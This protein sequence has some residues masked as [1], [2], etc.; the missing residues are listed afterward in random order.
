MAEFET[1]VFLQNHSPEEVHALMKRILPDDLDMSP[2]GHAYN[3]TMPTALVIAEVCEFVLPE[4]IKLIFPE[5]SY[6]EFVDAH[7]K[8]RGMTRRAASAASGKLTITGD[9]KTVIPA[10]S[11]FSTAAVNGEASVDYKTL[12]AVTIPDSGSVSVDVECATAGKIGNTN[13]NTIVLV[14]SR[15]TGVTGVTNEDPLTGGTEEE[16][17]ASL[18]ARIEEY[19]K[20]QGESYVGSAAD[21][22]RWATSVDG[23]GSATVVPAQDTSG[24]VTIIITDLNGEPAT[25][26][27][28]DAVYNKIM[29]PDKP[30]ER[31]A[32]INANLKVSPPATMKIAIKAT[33]ELTDDATLDAVKTAYAAQLALYLP[34]ALGEGEIKYSRVAAALAAVEGANDYSN[35]QIGIK[36]GD[37]VTY[38]TSNIAIPSSQLPIIEADDLIL[39]SGTV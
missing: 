10:G 15:L 29:N 32:P 8:V 35:L 27:L 37:A 28:C 7:A 34:V 4:V 30:N 26:Q 36:D 13:E 14:S 21:Y 31:L 39:T 5:F 12:E 19:N 16:D 3:L 20:S 17:D 2:G 24:L 33:V 9:P 1:P 18:I 38:G 25:E 22:K 6:G 23:V 11:L